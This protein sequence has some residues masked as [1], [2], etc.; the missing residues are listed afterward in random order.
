MFLCNCVWHKSDNHFSKEVPCLLTACANQSRAQT[1]TPVWED[2]W[3][4]SP[5]PAPPL[6]SS[7]GI[8]NWP[9][10]QVALETWAE[11]A[12]GHE[13]VRLAAVNLARTPPTWGWAEDPCGQERMPGWVTENRPCGSAWSPTQTWIRSLVTWQRWPYTASAHFEDNTDCF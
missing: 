6:S 10:A 1:E 3:T 11:P 12:R 8:G 4:D 13:A 5:A 9:L 7:L 2:K